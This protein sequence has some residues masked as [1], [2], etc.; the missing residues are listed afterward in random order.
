MLRAAVEAAYP[1]FL[2][3]VA[4]AMYAWWIISNLARGEQHRGAA[5]RLRFLKNSLLAAKVIMVLMAAAAG[6][7]Q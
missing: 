6:D 7:L 4:C 2:A 1:S 5:L 3:R